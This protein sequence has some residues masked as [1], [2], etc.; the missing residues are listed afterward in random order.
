MPVAELPALL[1]NIAAMSQMAVQGAAMVCVDD[2]AVNTK[3]LSGLERGHEGHAVR[4]VAR[5]SLLNKA[6]LIPTALLVSAVAPG[7]ILPLL[8][9]GGLHLA[10]EGAEKLLN[11]GAPEE[12]TM[13]TEKNKI[14]AALK[15][16]F[17]LSA[18]ITILTLSTVVGAPFLSQLA[19]LAITGAAATGGLYSMIG[20]ILKMNAASQWLLG[21]T[22]KN[23]VAKI[24][25]GFGKA[26]EKLEPHIM[27]GISLI[28]TAA[29]FVIGGGL[30]LHGI[31]GAEQLLTGAIGAGPLTG[32]LAETAIGLAVGIVAHPVIEAVSSRLVNLVAKVPHVKK[33]SIPE[34]IKPSGCEASVNALQNMPD[35][36]QALNVAAQKPANEDEPAIAVP[37][38]AKKLQL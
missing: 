18:E 14:R 6:F 33:I 31:P 9:L 38:P 32:L 4:R 28:G 22:G 29:L 3:L 25:R 30:M 2:V 15:V 10:S 37:V 24:A 23:P 8:A 11:R 34:R 5:F 27:K 1:A 35:V 13:K 16:D 17:I 36:K 7:A 21:R 12:D 20:G 26:L 19:V